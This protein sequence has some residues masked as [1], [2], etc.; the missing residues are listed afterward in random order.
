M[1]GSDAEPPVPTPHLA[2]PAAAHPG[3]RTRRALGLL[4]VA[5]GL[6]G[7]RIPFY[8]AG[9][10]QE[11]AYITWRCAVHLADTGQYSFNVPGR[12]CATTSHAYAFVAAAVRRVFG[13]RFIPAVL[14]VNTL[15][16]VAGAYLI[17]AALVEGFRRRLLLWCMLA[18][19]PVALEI[20]YSGMETA[21]L[22]LVVAVAF[23]ALAR[24]RVHAG[25]CAALA[26]LPWVRPDAIAFGGILLAAICWRTRRFHVPAALAL[27]VGLVALA[28]FNHLAFGSVLNRTIIAKEVAYGHPRTVGAVAARLWGVFFARSIFLPHG[29]KYLRPAGPVFALAGIPLCLWAVAAARKDRVRLVQRACLVAM[30]LLVPTAYAVGGVLFPWYLWPCQLLAWAVLLVVALRWGGTLR[31]R[32]RGGCLAGAAAALGI[33]WAGQCL[34]AWSRGTY[35]QRHRGGVG[36]YIRDHSRAGDTLFLEPAGY[37]P[38]Y[39]RRYT[40]DEIGL[41]TPEVTAYRRRYPQDWWIR[42]VQHKRPD[43]LLQRKH[44]L[45]H[46]TLEG[47]QLTPPEIDWFKAN[48]DLVKE[49]HYRPEDYY[50]HRLLLGVLRL[51]S[52]HSYYL[53]KR[54]PSA[55]ERGRAAPPPAG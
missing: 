11:D 7:V 22:V 27:L 19:M 37:I 16:L 1:N 38:F 50:R 30:V 29:T 14:V 41:G 24:G 34:M 42:F 9:D 45:Q 23:G 49:F 28:G 10:I 54:K 6:V 32:L 47:Y 31:R 33:L 3:G 13:E 51:G 44:M 46:R 2:A 8:L 15:C 21:L 18:L 25:H 55:G 4:A 39:G 40:Y 36:R 53:Y 48:Y 5:G 20:S 43:L 12:E 26:M 35:E 17:S 52:A